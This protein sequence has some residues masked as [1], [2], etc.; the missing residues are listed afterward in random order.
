V[1]SLD[2]SFKRAAGLKR[3]VDALKKQLKGMSLVLMWGGLH[4]MTVV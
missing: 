4:F 3:E 2:L 1:N